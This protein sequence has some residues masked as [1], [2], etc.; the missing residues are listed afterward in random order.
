MQISDPTQAQ[1]AQVAQHPTAQAQPA[2]PSDPTDAVLDWNAIAQTATLAAS[3]PAPQQFRTLAITHGAIFDAVNAIERRY[4][5]YSV[6]IKAPAGASAAAAAVAAGH[7]V[8][9][10]L[11]PAQKASLD[12]AL[13]ASLAKIPDGEAK[14]GGI[15]VGKE[16]AEKLVAIRS[17]DR[18]ARSGE[19]KA[20]K[21]VGIWQPTPPLFAPA[22]LPNWS[23]VTPFVIK[24]ADQ[25]KIPAPLPLNSDA[26]A[27]ELNEV[28]LLGGRY[29]TARTA[30][31]TATAIF[32][33]ISPVPLWNTPARAA[34]TEKG[35]NLIEN[36][37]LFALLNFAGADA[38]IAGYEVKYKYKLWRP[39]VAIPNAAE[40][41]NPI[42]TPDPNWESLI[43]T[44]AH[45]DYISG[46]CVT[47]GA[48]ERVLQ[49]F[50]GSDS[51]KVSLIFPANAG[52]TRSYTSFSQISKELGESRI[53]AGLHTR[54]ADTQG[55]VL[56]KQVGDYVFR[57]ALQP[58][59]S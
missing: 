46:H 8:L 15:N 20:Q 6:N 17:T 29:S 37:R 13:T 11:Y 52:V 42:I 30:E 53:W 49:R 35:N 26:Y 31:Q 50:F 1:T 41:G 34:A 19:Y 47:A 48:A 14:V 2:K 10:R 58:L 57:N 5:P 40:L 38:Y 22:L 39:V 7:G 45:P 4:T 18:S 44:P 3:A 43:V 27:K 23:E 16:V 32:S 25:F 59:K 51:V 28:K 21:A 55:D 12:A 54:T 9:T 36:A 56:G 24:R 33:A